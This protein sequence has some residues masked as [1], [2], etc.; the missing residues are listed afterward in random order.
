MNILY[1][2]I[3]ISEGIS[4]ISNFESEQK[5]F[6]RVSQ[7]YSNKEQTVIN[8]LR[9]NKISENEFQ[10]AILAFKAENR[11]EIW[12]GNTNL[13][14]QKIKEIEICAKSGRPGPKRKE[15]DGQV[16]EGFYFIQRFNPTSSFHLAL[17]V[18]YPNASD[19]IL[20]RGNNLGG[21]IMIHGECVTIGCLPMTNEGIEEIYIYAVKAKQNGQKKIPVYI[22]PFEPGS[23]ANSVTTKRY[24]DRTDVLTFWKNIEEG[25]KI[26]RKI[27]KPLSYSVNSKGRYVF[28]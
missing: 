22:F 11:L 16:P 17:E 12:A 23:G 20:G 2:L 3:L 13:K 15:G 18:S 19:R 24:N 5:L 6:P 27:G 9:E 1:L 26:F 7:A 8:T 10:L 28:N 21:E 14:M 4:K 25:Y